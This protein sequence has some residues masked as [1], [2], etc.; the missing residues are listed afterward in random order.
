MVFN[1]TFNSISVISWL[2]LILVEEIGSTPRK[3][4]TYLKI[5]TNFITLMLYRVH[6]A[7]ARF[8]LTIFLVIG[9]DCKGS[10]KSNYHT[11][12]PMTAPR[13][14]DC[15]FSLCKG[16]TKDYKINISCFFA[17]I[18]SWMSHSQDNVII[19]YY[20]QQCFSNIVAVS[21]Y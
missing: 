15:R 9:T 4:P 3:P 19:Q 2:L 6:L 12:T 1:A 17:K 8:E 13:S 20:S 16:Q 5:L 7:R 10:C 11:I 14:E 18:A 21:F